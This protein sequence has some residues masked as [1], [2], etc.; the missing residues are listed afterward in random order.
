MEVHTCPQC[1]VGT[2]K[3]PKDDHPAYFQCDSCMAIELL[4]SPMDYQ[5]EM[6]TVNTG[7]DIDIIAV[8]GGKKS[9]SRH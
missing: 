1:K 2:V 7:G 3:P 9:H 6:H 5:E 8:F 4:Y